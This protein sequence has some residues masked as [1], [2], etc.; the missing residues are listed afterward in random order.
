MAAE[1]K[2]VDATTASR[3]VAGGA[4]VVDIRS[5]QEWRAGHIEGSDRVAANRISSHSVGRADT[6]IAVCA[7]GS[8]SKKAAR[9]LAKEGYRV[10][11]LDGGL[12]AWHAAGLPL[13]SSNGQRPTI[14]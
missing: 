7:N 8:R 9:K 1:F 6:V 3:I 12:E 14:L 2:S 5:E 11:H 13:T 4:H 10:Y